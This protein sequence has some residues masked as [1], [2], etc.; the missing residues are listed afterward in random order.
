M[1]KLASWKLKTLSKAG[2]LT[3]IKIVINSLP[4]YYMSLF[5]MPKTI[6]LEIVKLQHRFFWGES[7]EGKMTTPAV[8]WES[9][10]LPKDLGGLGLG[11]ILYKK[12]ILLF[13]WWWRY[14]QSD[15]TFWKRL[16]ISVHNIKGLKA[17]SENFLKAREGLCALLT[18]NDAETFKVR[19]IVE[20]G[21][22]LSVG[23][24]DSIR[25]WHDKWC[26]SEP[27][28]VSFPRLLS[29]SSQKDFYIS[30]MGYWQDNSWIWAL[31]WRRRLYDWEIDDYLR[32]ESTIEH[33]HPSL[34]VS[35][36]I[37][38]RGSTSMDY[39]IG[40]IMEKL[41]DNWDPILPPQSIRLLWHTSD[42]PRA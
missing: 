39:P 7:R 41:Y 15:N 42:P 1:N 13:K 33:K 18:C 31:T 2:R 29:I 11:N 35:D 23:N 28:K 14:S 25:F 40:S 12:L 34:G 26:D 16:L 24:G 22:S 37:K 19:S 32:L 27:V 3:L 21:L 5:R 10:E 9:I 17:S 4:V 30:Q 8:K 20:D 38:W 6:A 36:G